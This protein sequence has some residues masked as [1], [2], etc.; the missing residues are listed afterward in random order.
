MGSFCPGLGGNTSDSLIIESE[1]LWDLNAH[2]LMGDPWPVLKLCCGMGLPSRY[3]RCPKCDKAMKIVK[4]SSNKND[5]HKFACRDSRKDSYHYTKR[6]IRSG[7]WF[8][9]ITK[10]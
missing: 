5:Q 7:P 2:F 1:F 4:S 10:L 8:I 3:Y 6:S 9:E